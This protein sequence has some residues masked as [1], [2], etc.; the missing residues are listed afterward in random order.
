MSRVRPRGFTLTELLVVMAA[1]G[2]LVATAWPSYHGHLLRAARIDAVDALTR[3]QMAQERYRSAHGGYA[4]QLPLLGLAPSSP[5][6]RYAI[7]L[8]PQGGEHYEAR[9]EAQGAQSGDRECAVLTLVVE[10]G[11]ARTGPDARCWS[12]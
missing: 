5:Q 1:A 10:Q 4:A 6:G 3:V 12:R 9:A 11:F 8:A 7:A 2:L